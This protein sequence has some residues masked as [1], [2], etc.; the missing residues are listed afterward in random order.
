MQGLI[1]GNVHISGFLR[2]QVAAGQN[3]DKQCQD[4]PVTELAPKHSCDERKTRELHAASFGYAIWIGTDD[5]YL[6]L[7]K[8]AGTV[9]ITRESVSWWYRPANHLIC[10]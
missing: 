1:I 9:G 10:L 7:F 2:P 5:G 4:S 8:L 3:A 6:I